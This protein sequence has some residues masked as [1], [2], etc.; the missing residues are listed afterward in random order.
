MV[1]AVPTLTDIHH[2][3]LCYSKDRYCGHPRQ[4]GIY[5]FGNGE[6]VVMHHRAQSTYRTLTRYQARLGRYWLQ[7][8]LPDHAPA[9]ARPCPD[10]AE[11][12]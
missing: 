5:N 12:Q 9:F 6:I 11:R 8:P 1:R 10:L 2:S 3:K 4:C 7:A